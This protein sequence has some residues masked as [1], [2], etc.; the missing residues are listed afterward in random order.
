MTETR[1]GFLARLME[2]KT[3]TSKPRTGLRVVLGAMLAY[4]GVSHVTV[5]R[6]EFQAQ[7]QSSCR[8]IRTLWSWPQALPK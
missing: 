1:K 2:G 5:A 3:A 7:F 8:S 6:Q 4:A